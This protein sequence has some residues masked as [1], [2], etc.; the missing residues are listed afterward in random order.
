M[1]PGGCDKT[2]ARYEAAL[3]A[4]TAPYQHVLLLGD[5]M[6][7]T[8]SLMFA[9]LATNVQAFT[10]QVDLRSSSIRPGEEDVWFDRLRQR[11]LDGA[12]ACAGEVVVH[13]GTWAHD[14]N[15]ARVLPEGGGSPVRLAVYGVDSHRLALA[16]D[17][18]GR[19]EGLVRSAV[20]RAQGLADTGSL[21]LSNLF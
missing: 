4:A 10:P 3:R 21:R 8:A 2:Y 14:L 7:A 12:A 15:Q 9:H 6:G 13:T 16:L 5:S 17:R 1:A 11:C 20:L 18:R 19:L